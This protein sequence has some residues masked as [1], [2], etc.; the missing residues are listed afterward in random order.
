[1]VTDYTAEKQAE[2][3]SQEQ[4]SEARLSDSIG[5]SASKIQSG[6]SNIDL[7]TIASLAQWCDRALKRIGR[8]NFEILVQVSE[9]TGRL[10]TEEKEILLA[11][12]PLFDGD[13]KDN[14]S[15][16]DI[17]YLLAQLEGLLS[18]GA[19]NDPRMLSFLLNDDMDMFSPPRTKSSRSE[20]STSRK[21]SAKESD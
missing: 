12:L 21:A 5:S 6:A 16:T 1:V 9:M 4:Q 7:M 3:I 13:G 20:S 18:G 17:V 11:L 2:P 8:E 19:K 15:S 10:P 14:V